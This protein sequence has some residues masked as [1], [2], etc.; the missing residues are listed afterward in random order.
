MT[1]IDAGIKHSLALKSN[2]TVWAW[3]NNVDGELGNGTTTNS[4]VPIA[5]AGLNAIAVS[6]GGNTSAVLLMD[7]TIRMF[8]Q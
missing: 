2:G 6:A 1:A 5:V 4:N 3:G 7:G 8:G